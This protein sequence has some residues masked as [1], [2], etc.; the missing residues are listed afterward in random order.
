MIGRLDVFL[1]YVGMHAFRKLWLGYFR[2]SNAFEVLKNAKLVYQEHYERWVKCA[3]RGIGSHMMGPAK[4]KSKR[5]K[6]TTGNM[7]LIVRKNMYA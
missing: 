2:A 3:E 1:G 4:K 5:T 6:W 7:T